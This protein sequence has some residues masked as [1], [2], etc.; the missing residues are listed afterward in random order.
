[1]PKS[2]KKK[3]AIKIVFV[4]PSGKASGE[5]NLPLGSNERQRRLNHSEWTGIQAIRKFQWYLAREDGKGLDAATEALMRLGCL[6]EALQ[7][8]IR[9]P[10]HNLKKLRSLLHFWNNR[11][12][13]AIPRCLGDNLGTFTDAIRHFAPPYNGG[14]LTLYRGQSRER[15]ESGVF[16]TAW[17]GRL[18]VAQQFAKLRNTPWVVLEFSATPE[19]IVARVGDFVSTVKTNP[20][21]GL[22]YEDEYLVDPR[23]LRSLVKVH[24]QG[25]LDVTRR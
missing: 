16:G 20:K 12:L 5:P 4:S 23:G 13:W 15:Y 3:K 14:A 9:S 19:Q 8:S 2:S 1:M 18:S 22:D 25:V 21:S 10:K 7:R 11:G 24:S 6:Q 17:T